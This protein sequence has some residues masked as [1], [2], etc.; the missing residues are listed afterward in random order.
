MLNQIQV[1]NKS[2]NV[3]VQGADADDPSK[4]SNLT[5][6]KDPKTGLS[7]LAVVPIAHVGYDEFNDKYKVDSR[8]KSTLIREQVFNHLISGG[9][10]RFVA[11]DISQFSTTPIKPIDYSLYDKKMIAINNTHDAPIMVSVYGYKSTDS[12]LTSEG[13]TKAVDILT[14]ATEVSIPANSR[15]IFDQSTL[16]KLANPYI[17]LAIRCSRVASPTPT[18]GEV[19]VQFYGR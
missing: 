15:Y 11:N 7:Y 4:K 14:G 10:S 19:S 9:L 16:P 6:I 2:L 1:L 13:V 5:T 18:T 3:N 12:F 17:A 8:V